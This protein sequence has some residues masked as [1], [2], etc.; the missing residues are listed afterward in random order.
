M[1]VPENNSKC[2]YDSSLKKY[3][4]NGLVKESIT[5]LTYCRLGITFIP[6]IVRTISE[7]VVFT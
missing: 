1:I 2:H 6:Y 4:I 5:I 3:F 7:G